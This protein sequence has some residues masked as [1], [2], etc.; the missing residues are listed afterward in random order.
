MERPPSWTCGPSLRTQ[1]RPASRAEG[2]WDF[3]SDRNWGRLPEHAP[4]LAHDR[5]EYRL[6]PQGER[7]RAGREAVNKCSNWSTCTSTGRNTP[8]N[9]P[10]ASASVSDRSP[11]HKPEALLLTNRSVRSTPQTELRREV[12][13]MVQSDL[14]ALHHSRSEALEMGDQ[15][16]VLNRGR[17]EHGRAL[18]VYNHPAS[19]FVA[20][21]WALPMYCWDDSRMIR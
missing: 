11:W 16:A 15:I 13:F 12:Q 14:S 7:S 19:E 10:A 9:C 1:A 17:I 18:H 4:L 3:P 2:G 5:A 21:F 20:G 8:M 6:R